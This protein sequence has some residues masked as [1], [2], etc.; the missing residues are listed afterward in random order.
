M[1]RV[2]GRYV[3]ADYKTNRLALPEEALTAWH[4]RQEALDAAMQD[5]HYPLQAALYAVAVHRYLRW[6]V[7]GYDPAVHLGGVAYLFLRGMSGPDVTTI[8]GQPCG[9]FTWKPPP[10]FVLDLSELLD[11]GAS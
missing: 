2:D 10:A 6:R 9:V 5:A 3:V 11:R 4:Y 8:D 1:A 7:S